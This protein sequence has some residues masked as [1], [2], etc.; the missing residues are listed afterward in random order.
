MT[1]EF[2]NIESFLSVLLPPSMICVPPCFIDDGNYAHISFSLFG[3]PWFIMNPS[4]AVFNNY[5]GKVAFCWPV[6]TPLDPTSTE[7]LTLEYL[8]LKCDEN[9]LL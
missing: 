6:L 4:D 7:L 8:L 1:P 5:A 2:F 3:D 9:V